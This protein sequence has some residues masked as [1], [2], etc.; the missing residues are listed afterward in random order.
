LGLGT[1]GKLDQKHTYLE[2]FETLCWRMME[3]ISGTYR[4]RHKEVLN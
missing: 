2:S 4:V 3:K 1:V